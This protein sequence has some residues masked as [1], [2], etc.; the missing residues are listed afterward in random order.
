MKYLIHYIIIF[1]LVALLASCSHSRKFTNSYYQE[2]DSLFQT[3]QLRFNQLYKQHPFAVEMTDKAFRRMKFEIITDTIKYI[4]SFT[5]GEPGFTDTLQKYRFNVKGVTD[6]IRDMQTV[7]C[8]WITN[9]DYYENKEKKFLVF[10]SIRHKQLKTFLRPEKYFTLAFF[11]RPRRFDARGRLLD[12][13]DR[14]TLF[15]ING[16]LFRRLND[17]VCYSM[18]ANFR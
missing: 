12:N 9:L 7:H 15:K 16:G 2:N 3:I 6:L 10:L 4:Y 14:K 5:I 8:T 1:L 17:R 13:Q 18:S 11:D